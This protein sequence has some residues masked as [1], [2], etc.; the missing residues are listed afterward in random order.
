MW[1]V[2]I[3]KHGIVDESSLFQVPGTVNSQDIMARSRIRTVDI[4]LKKIAELTTS[5]V[6]AGSL[7]HSQRSSYLIKCNEK[8]KMFVPQQAKTSGQMQAPVHI[9][10]HIDKILRL[11]QRLLLLRKDS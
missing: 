8:R 3:E 2:S 10:I 1:P 7:K 6:K 9:V 5:S 11:L 4:S